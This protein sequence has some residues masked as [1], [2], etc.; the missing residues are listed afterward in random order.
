[1]LNKIKELYAI[2]ASFEQEHA[3]VASNLEKMRLDMEAQLATYTDMNAIVLKAGLENNVNLIVDAVMER[4]NLQSTLDALIENENGLNE[5]IAARN[6]V[7]D[8]HARNAA[9]QYAYQ[10]MEHP[11][12]EDAK[13]LLSKYPGALKIHQTE[14]LTAMVE[15]EQVAA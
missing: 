1:M 5:H 11:N 12:I 2:A 8:R 10:L 13:V 15:G 4:T 7:L 14:T 9:K 3:H 6:N